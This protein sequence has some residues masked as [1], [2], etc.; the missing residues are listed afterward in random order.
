M[1]GEQQG[2]CMARFDPNFID[3]ADLDGLTDL[4]DREQEMR[5]I[6][7]LLADP[8]ARLITIT[9][10]AGV[11][12]SRLAR[13]ALALHYRCRSDGPTIVAL[14]NR[15]DP[16]RAVLTA[17]APTDFDNHPAG[18][19]DST[20][21]AL[22]RCFTH[23]RPLL[24][25]DDCD[26]VAARLAPNIAALLSRC[27]RL[28]IIVTS[29][30]PLNL[31]REQL[32]RLR[33]LATET[34]GPHGDRLRSPAGRLL[35][36]SIGTQAL[37]EC[38]TADSETLAR[39]ARELDGVPAALEL[40]AATIDRIGPAQTLQ[41]L[42]SGQ[43]LLPSPLLD[44]PAR[45]RTI[46]DCI[47]WSVADL[48]DR[49]LDL[50]LGLSLCQL[51]VDLDV[52]FH[53]TGG[54]TEWLSDTLGALMHR[55]LLECTM[56]ADGHYA[57]ST[58]GIT[59]VYCRQL[60]EAD[61][62]RATRIQRY[63][64]QLV[65]RLAADILRHA[66]RPGCRAEAIALA[67]K[68]CP[69]LIST[70]EGLSERGE[71]REALRLIAPLAEFWPQLGLLARVEAIVEA[72]QAQGDTDPRTRREI[73]PACLA[74]LGRWALRSG[75]F[76]RAVELLTEAASIYR[77]N[78]NADAE[79]E[80]MRHLGEG[81]RESGDL[82]RA[83][84][85]FAVAMRHATL[86]SPGEVDAIELTRD[87]ARVGTQAPRGK[88]PRADIRDRINALAPEGDR[89]RALNALGRAHLGSGATHSALVA[90]HSTLR[91]PNI[92]DHL[93]EALAAIEGCAAA[94]AQADPAFAEQGH[95][96][97]A[98]AR[99]L[100][101]EYLVP[102]PD[103]AADTEAMGDHDDRPAQRLEEV[104][105]RALAG[106]DLS[107]PNSTSGL[108]QL[109]RRQ[110]EIAFMVAQGMTNRMIA[111]R[112]G[113]AEWTVVNHLRHVMNKLDCPSRLHIALLIERESQY[114]STPAAAQSHPATRQRA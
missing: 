35:L 2:G 87:I 68:W 71:Y 64:V 62:E 95:A 25:L 56:M 47:A 91:N 20:I 58:C 49:A 30:R 79:R 19:T 114:T 83:E 9:G 59:R 107:A 106:P 23:G 41:R 88:R 48:D 27:P 46:G 66:E 15:A 89:L 96:L 36:S 14:A 7:R 44:I 26:P 73:A 86:R 75:R 53:F 90:F 43:D 54:D 70:A 108:S 16:W 18:D 28:R 31:Y 1:A 105:A 4:P 45:H 12:K 99:R 72:I 60:L 82:P 57:Y 39:I 81:L 24:L 22:A 84:E 33:P 92:A 32:L 111:T 67:E 8:N 109:T 5:E 3:V 76:T 51:V 38:T 29:R 17:V 103:A 74:L 93:L 78:G 10:T 11:G 104:V 113:I 85:C 77:A 13:A 94:Y 55:G 97:A 50:L 69:E 65:G 80:L 101:C 110:H 63:R 98:D 61:R 112:L 34:P 102:R 6:R 52:I 37:A 100:R 40:A 42:I 21:D